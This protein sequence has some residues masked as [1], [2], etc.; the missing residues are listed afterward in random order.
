MHHARVSDKSGAGQNGTR[1][2]IGAIRPPKAA[3]ILAAVYCTESMLPPASRDG[4]IAD[5]G[6]I[7]AQAL[8]G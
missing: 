7:I 1:N 5:A 6:R 3:P 4:L 8:G 2:D